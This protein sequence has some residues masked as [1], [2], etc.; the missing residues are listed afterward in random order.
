MKVV[1]HIVAAVCAVGV[2]SLSGAADTPEVAALKELVKRT[3]EDSPV[4][5]YAQGCEFSLGP[6]TTD[7]HLK[8]LAKL[9]AAKIWKINLAPTRTITAKG[10][11]VQFTRAGLTE[12]AK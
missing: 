3:G 12:L 9:S 10:S 6:K 11:E 8:E 1:N 2:P 4:Q 5:V 7:A